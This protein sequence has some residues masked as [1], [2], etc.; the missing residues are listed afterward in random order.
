MMICLHHLV[1]FC[2]GLLAV[3]KPTC[4]QL[5]VPPV[6]LGDF[7]SL[8]GG[9][10]NIAEFGKALRLP[11]SWADKNIVQYYQDGEMFYHRFLF[12]NSSHV[13][14]FPFK[15]N[16]PMTLQIHDKTIE[17]SYIL[18][19]TSDPYKAA[20]FSRYEERDG[21]M[22][23]TVESVFSRA[24][25]VTT[26]THADVLDSIMARR[27]YR[28]IIPKAALGYYENVGNQESRNFRDF[29]APLPVPQDASYG[30]NNKVYFG[31][32]ARHF[33]L[34][35]L[36]DPES[37]S[38]IFPFVVGE[39]Q[40]KLVNGSNMEYIIDVEKGPFPNITLIR[41]QFRYP[42]GGLS[43]VVEFTV[44]SG[45][46][47]NATFKRDE[48]LAT[49]HFRRALPLHFYG[50]FVGT[51]EEE[52][53]FNEFNSVFQDSSIAL[54]QAPTKIRFYR[55][56]VTFHHEI[57][58]MFGMAET[59]NIPFQLDAYV[60]RD[61]VGKTFKVHYY[62]DGG[63]EPKLNIAF[64]H[65][66]GDLSFTANYTFFRNGIVAN[67]QRKSAD[68]NKLPI[69]AT[70]FYRRQLPLLILGRYVSET[71]TDAFKTLANGIFF[72]ELT[73]KTTI[74]YLALPNGTYIQK[75][76]YGSGVNTTIREV[77][78][79]LGEKQEQ[80][81]NGQWMMEYIYSAWE[82]ERTFLESVF[83][84]KKDGTAV[85]SF[86]ES[87]RIDDFTADGYTSVYTLGNLTA[88]RKYRR[89]V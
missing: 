13:L 19:P 47:A 62:Y 35:Y 46:S 22:R 15:F 51:P 82:G 40:Q 57:T 33:V 53:N 78:F 48:I 28:R 2:G 9:R 64:E 7:E 45:K 23:F 55:N 21:M 5:E 68:A 44:L 58:N 86:G 6:V 89:H 34:K 49:R 61:I 83:T 60:E 85:P 66:G 1:L 10:G 29:A 39:K 25:M 56:G 36:F 63:Q 54:A 3:C 4:Q 73:T 12:G 70:R 18:E 50:T 11:S 76:S 26:Y 31:Q 20:I 81:V 38:Y 67:Y 79:V 14:S 87:S 80:L 32:S 27:T 72:P 69:I 24:G 59:A 42:E 41:A 74:E 43:W 88:K 84:E 16:E 30:P 52:A 75:L 65:V 77:S 37:Y 17:Y 8:P 71:N